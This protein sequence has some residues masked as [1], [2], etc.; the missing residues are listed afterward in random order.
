MTNEKARN[1]VT[2][3]VSGQTTAVSKTLKRIKRAFP[4]F[5]EGKTKP[6]DSDDGVHVFLTI[7][8]N[9]QENAA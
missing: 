3:K 8:F 9:E 6:N 4:L 7:A 1:I 5:L 2:L